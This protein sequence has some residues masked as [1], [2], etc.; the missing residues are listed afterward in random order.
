[1][2]GLVIWLL[3]GSG[4]FLLYA[5]IKNEQPQDI[6]TGYLGTSTTPKP[7]ST[8]GGA[9]TANT[10]ATGLNS[11]QPGTFNMWTNSTIPEGAVDTHGNVSNA[12]PGYTPATHIPTGSG[13]LAYAV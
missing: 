11:G 12:P 2:N 5:A 9:N 8:W 6:L 7:I 10:P 13:R 4:V 3:A 1:M